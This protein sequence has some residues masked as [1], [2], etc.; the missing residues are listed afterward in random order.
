MTEADRSS[1]VALL[2]EEA[3]P[4]IHTTASFR[5]KIDALFDEAKPLIVT[6]IEPTRPLQDLLN[7]AALESWAREGIAHHKGKRDDCAFCRQQLPADLWQTLANH[8]NQASETLGAAI[9]ACAEKIR[10]ELQS[11]AWMPVLE[12]GQFYA[13]ERPAF[14]TAKADLV[15][16]ID[17]YKTDLQKLSD[18]LA[19]RRASL[20]RSGKFPLRNFDAAAAEAATQSFNSVL[21]ANNGRSTTLNKDKDAARLALRRSKVAEFLATLDLPGKEATILQLRDK[22]AE[23]K[24]TADTACQA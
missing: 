10:V 5:S 7:D 24:T 21:A 2:K 19:T 6:V 13:S 12:A 3:L 18:A 1:Y 22:N 11:V 23:A 17:S 14:E 15:K 9:D 4:E 20:F 16:F 8:F